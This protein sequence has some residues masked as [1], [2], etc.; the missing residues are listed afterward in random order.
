MALN[1]WDVSF[2]PAPLRRAVDSMAVELMQAYMDRPGPG[3]DERL[4]DG[5]GPGWQGRGGL[6]AGHPGARDWRLGEKVK[7]LSSKVFRNPPRR[8]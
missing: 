8:L 3:G 2:W 5:E 4:T 6:E 1:G 7:V